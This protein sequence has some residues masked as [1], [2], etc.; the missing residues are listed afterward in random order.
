MVQTA[1]NA[2]AGSRD[3]FQL[4]GLTPAFDVDVA[5]LAARYRVLQ[6]KFHPDRFSAVSAAEARAAAQVSAEINA[7]YNILRDPVQRAGFMLER[8]GKDK[9]ALERTPVAGEFLM[10]QIELREAVQA[11]NPDDQEGRNQL[12]RAIDQLFDDA[13]QAFKQHIDSD[14]LDAAGTAWVHLLYVNKLR[15]EAGAV[16][17]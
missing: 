1:E 14:D 5:D 3:Y 15:Q 9:Q 4:F 2:V 6:Q 17:D 16:K 12:Q 10:Q 7:G 11:L 13:L 8:R